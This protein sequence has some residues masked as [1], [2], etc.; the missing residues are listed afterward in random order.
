MFRIVSIIGFLIVLVWII[1][2]F[3]GRS[4]N[5]LAIKRWLR[6]Q[7][8]TV[9]N[10]GEEITSLNYLRSFFYLLAVLA[11][12]VLAFTGFVPVIILGKHPSGFLLILHVTA[13]PFLAVSL[14]LL[15][16]FYAQRNRFSQADLSF[17]GGHEKE[18]T[19]RGN[20]TRI[21]I[22]KKICFWLLIGLSIPLIS[23]ILLSMFTIYGTGG[24]SFLLHLHGYTALLFVI[25]AMIYAYFS[26]IVSKD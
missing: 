17:W 19:G 12:L 15:S 2:G 22:L 13:V 11:V 21:I 14:A 7:K 20:T 18:K 24:Q 1:R 23:S 6:R 5:T 25:V 4:E 9:F 10:R 16:L 26:I 3:A 8:Q